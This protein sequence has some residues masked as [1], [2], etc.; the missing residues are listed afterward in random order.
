MS[1]RKLTPDEAV[2][3]V[4]EYLQLGGLLN[5]DLMEHDKVRDMVRGLRDCVV[6]LQSDLHAAK[7]VGEAMSESRRAALKAMNQPRPT[8]RESE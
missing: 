1:Y 2:A 3:M 8:G 5:P 4:A 7:L 6:E